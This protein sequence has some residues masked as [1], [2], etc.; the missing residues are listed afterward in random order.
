M[1]ATETQTPSPFLS[2][3]FASTRTYTLTLTLI[4][5]PTL[6]LSS[7]FTLTRTFTSTITPSLTQ[8]SSP[9]ITMTITI[10]S[11][12]YPYPEGT[13]FVYPNPFNP[14][15]AIN[16]QIKFENII[17]ESIVEIYTLSSEIV[18]YFIIKGNTVYWDGKNI[19]NL[20]GSS[21]IYYY[22]I[23]EPKYRKTY[24]REK[25]FIVN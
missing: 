15:T 3:T 5:T 20:Q 23:K 14:I 8:T 11:T 7:T 13:P 24:D 17:S 10:T 4:S 21:G 2:N 12:P 25:I 1:S 6:F 19:R 9:T 18:T 22:L 16:G